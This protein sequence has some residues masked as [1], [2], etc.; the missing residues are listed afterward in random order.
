MFVATDVM[1]GL[2]LRRVEPRRHQLAERSGLTPPDGPTRP[3][4]LVG[5]NATNQRESQQLRAGRD[6]IHADPA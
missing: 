2:L 3:P 6:V 4:V 5:C 1:D